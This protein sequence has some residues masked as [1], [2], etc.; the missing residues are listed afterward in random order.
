MPNSYQRSIEIIRQNQSPSGA[1]LASPNFPTYGYCWLR[2]SSYIAYSMSLAGENDSAEAYF[3]WVHRTLE[4]Y[5]SKVDLLALY[6]SAG[7]KPGGDEFL[8]TRYMLDGEEV[9]G[10]HNWGNFQMDGYGTWLWALGE[11]FSLTSKYLLEAWE[12]AAGLAANYLSA[13]WQCYCDCCCGEVP[14]QDAPTYAG[15]YCRTR[16][17]MRSV[18]EPYESNSCTKSKDS[19]QR[20]EG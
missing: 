9:L 19:P 4:R 7:E 13:S 17:S 5:G 20:R 3:H 18:V 16:V 11:H 12:H 14:Q 10:D 1:Y 8:H 15:D 6:L 2:D